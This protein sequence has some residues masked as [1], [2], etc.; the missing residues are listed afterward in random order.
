MPQETTEEGG[1]TGK[2]SRIKVPWL[3]GSNAY[4]FWTPRRLSLCKQPQSSSKEFFKTVRLSSCQG[5][6]SA[7]NSFSFCD[8]GI[9]KYMR[10]FRALTPGNSRRDDHA[11]C[12]SGVNIV[13]DAVTDGVSRL[14]DF[15]TCMKPNSCIQ[16]LE[17][18]YSPVAVEEAM[19]MSCAIS[20]CQVSSITDLASI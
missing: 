8:R 14:R 18:E 6:L 3:C 10:T 11:E 17:L 2:S 19:G 4:S 13:D 20:L 12:R 9:H 7:G 1:S 15:S 16:S 5:Q